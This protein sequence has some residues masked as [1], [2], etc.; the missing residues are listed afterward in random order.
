MRIRQRSYLARTGGPPNA[1]GKIAMQESLEEVIIVINTPSTVNVTLAVTGI[2]V[3]YM[4]AIMIVEEAMS[5][6]AIPSL[7][8]LSQQQLQ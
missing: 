6:L 1:L 5:I 4:V 3:N 2:I 8:P 7:T